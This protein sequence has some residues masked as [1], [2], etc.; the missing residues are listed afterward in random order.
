MKLKGIILKTFGVMITF[1]CFSQNIF[2]KQQSKLSTTEME[3][4]L[5][6]SVAKEMSKNKIVGLSIAVVD[7][8]GILLSEGFGKAD[9]ENNVVANSSTLFPIA[10]VTKTFTELP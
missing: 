10:S 7:S 5:R 3:E 4:N 2:Y 8:N 9:K 6:T 1:N